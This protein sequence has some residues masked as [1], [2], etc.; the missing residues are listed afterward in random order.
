MK[1]KIHQVGEP[2]LRQQARPLSRDENLTEK[3]QSLI[4]W[5]RETMRDAPG[6]GLAAP[7]IGLPIQVA[8]IEDREDYIKK[9]SPVEASE[10][11]RVPVPFQVV[12]NPKLT[13]IGSEKAEFF[14]GC[15]SL[16]GFVALVPRALEVRVDCLNERAEPV[17][18]EAKGWYARILQHE[19][20]HLQGLLYI[21]HMKSRTFSSVENHGRYGSNRN[22]GK[23][24][25]N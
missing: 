1:L 16:A 22:D 8:V 24:T 4:E 2:V 5:M 14:E 13:V 18:I 12:I 7:Q 9:L 21:D 20:D 10:R 3:H 11:S 25:K 6:V 23:I 15:L 17:T 19:I